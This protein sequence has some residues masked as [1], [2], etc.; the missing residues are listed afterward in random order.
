MHYKNKTKR[1]P[2]I[3]RAGI[4][5]SVAVAA[6]MAYN[7]L[8]ANRLR[9]QSSR[10]SSNPTKKTRNSRSLNGHTHRMKRLFT[11]VLSMYKFH[12]L[13]EIRHMNFVQDQL[14]NRTV[15]EKMRVTLVSMAAPEKVA[16]K[17]RKYYQKRHPIHVHAWKNM[18]SNGTYTSIDTLKM[19]DILD[20]TPAIASRVVSE[21]AKIPDLRFGV[22]GWTPVN[23]IVDLFIEE[24]YLNSYKGTDIRK[25]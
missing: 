15:F 14:C 3:V 6:T 5:L 20:Y 23:P 1:G 2:A 10:R 19:V 8:K 12:P 7:K 13:G 11:K 18:Q 21:Y 16:L 4:V 9:R 22:L 17:I 25:L 24:E